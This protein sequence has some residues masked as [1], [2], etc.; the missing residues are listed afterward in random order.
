MRTQIHKIAL[1]FGLKL[2]LIDLEG[3]PILGVQRSTLD[4]DG[5]GFSV[6]DVADVAKPNVAPLILD[7]VLAR[8]ELGDSLL[9]LE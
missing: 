6:T 2:R 8:P 7:F 4:V 3:G 9:L 5:D 1:E